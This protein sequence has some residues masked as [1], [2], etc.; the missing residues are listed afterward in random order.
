MKTSED[1]KKSVEENDIQF[2]PV[3]NCSMCGYECGF[4]FNVMTNRTLQ[5]V[6]YDAG[7]RC[8]RRYVLEPRTWDHVAHQYNLNINNPTTMKEYNEFWKFD[9]ESTA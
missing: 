7:C 3:H 1:F 9:N 6:S 8:T 4:I 2:W 5:P